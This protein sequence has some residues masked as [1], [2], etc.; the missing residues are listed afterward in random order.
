MRWVIVLS[1]L[2]SFACVRY[3]RVSIG[4]GHPAGD[5]CLQ[6]CKQ[7]HHDDDDAIVECAS[8]CPGAL[9]QDDECERTVGIDGELEPATGC[10]ATSHVRW[11]RVAT[12]AGV[13][14]GSAL[15]VTA[16]VFAAFLSAPTH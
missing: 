6:I 4:P 10:V 7:A 3:Q 12:I 8:T 15:I 5:T 16:L 14:A 2:S 13:I 9:V 11:G 1:L